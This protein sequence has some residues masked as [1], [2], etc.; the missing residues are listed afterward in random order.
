M[1]IGKAIMLIDQNTEVE[2]VDKRGKPIKIVGLT[3]D[4]QT[5]KLTIKVD[6]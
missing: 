6:K 3:F 4:S 5:N 1:I 2:T